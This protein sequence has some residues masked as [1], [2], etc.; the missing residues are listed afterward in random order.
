MHKPLKLTLLCLIVFTA[1]FFT[2]SLAFNRSSSP[3]STPVFSAA[4][5]DDSPSQTEEDP[6]FVVT[7]L[8]GTVVVYLSSQTNEP[9]LFTEIKT[10]SLRELDRNMIISGIKVY[11][12]EDALKLLEDLGS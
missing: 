2:C 12:H 8:H 1:S 3:S 7:D 9:I 4:E 10:S 5:P 6:C 11:S